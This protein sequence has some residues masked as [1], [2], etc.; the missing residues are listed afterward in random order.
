MLIHEVPLPVP[1]SLGIS[2]NLG[3]ATPP[4]SV[5]LPEEGSALPAVAF[6]VCRVFNFLPVSAGLARRGGRGTCATAGANHT[7]LTPLLVCGGACRL[8]L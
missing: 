6:D 1:A 3:P 4:M 8:P 7:P 2:F 5:A